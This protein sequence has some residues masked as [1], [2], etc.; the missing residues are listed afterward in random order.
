MARVYRKKVLIEGLPFW[1]IVFAP[2]AVGVIV[3]TK[4]VINALV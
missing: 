2:W 1:P 4:A 3:I